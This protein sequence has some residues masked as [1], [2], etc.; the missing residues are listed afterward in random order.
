[1]K[2]IEA[3]IDFSLPYFKQY[4]QEGKKIYDFVENHINV[5]PV[6]LM[7]LHNEHGYFFLKGGEGADTNVFEYQLTFYE[8]PADK[9][10]AI[11]TR[12]LRSYTFGLSNSFNNIKSELLRDNPDLPNPATFAMES[13]LSIP[14]ADTFLPVAKRMLVKRICPP[15]AA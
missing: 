14:V 4:L 1:M 7:P 6:G 13:D 12:Y 11:R 2:E 8:T 5:I 10:R 9:Y 3:I 15:G